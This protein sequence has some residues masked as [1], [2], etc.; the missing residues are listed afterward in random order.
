MDDI[1]LKRNRRSGGRSARREKRASPLPDNIK[2]I[3]PGMIGGTYKPLSASDIASIEQTI[4]QLLDEIGLSQAPES[5]VTKMQNYGAILGED[6]RLRFPQKIVKKALS[7]TQKNITL[8]GQDP[9]YDIHLKKN[10]VHYGTAGAAVNVVDPYNKTYR[11]SEAQDIYNAAC[12]AE[13]LDNIHFFQRPMVATNIGDPEEMDLN[14][15]YACLSGTQKHV[16]ISFTEADFIKPACEIL[17][18]I[19]LLYTSP[20]PR[21]S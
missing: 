8:L 21:D 9:K 13:K 11:P 4:Y 17:H 2:P 19:C 18:M 6:N 20:S 10:H 16:G 1:Q 7:E 15:L 5:G 3:A 14:T 12:I